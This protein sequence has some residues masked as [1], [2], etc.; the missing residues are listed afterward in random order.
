MIFSENTSFY[1]NF[2][3]LKN[4]INDKLLNKGCKFA[5]MIRVE[6]CDVS[7]IIKSKYVN[8]IRFAFYY[9]NIYF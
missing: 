9:E 3:D 1:L 4:I 8:I 5:M 7:K 6:D 2:S